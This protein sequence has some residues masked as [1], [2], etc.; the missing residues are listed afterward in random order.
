[1]YLI[2]PLSS[3]Q[4]KAQIAEKI[5]LKRYL[6]NCKLFDVTNCVILTTFLQCIAQSVFMAYGLALNSGL[7][8]GN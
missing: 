5:P 4:K 1:M 6:L 8:F 7:P 2:T 3:S